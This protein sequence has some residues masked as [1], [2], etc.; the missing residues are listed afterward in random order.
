MPYL[1]KLQVLTSLHKVRRMTSRAK[2]RNYIP[3]SSELVSCDLPVKLSFSLGQKILYKAYELGHNTNTTSE[4]VK[5]H[6]PH[7]LLPRLIF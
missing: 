5:Q 2:V 4:L 6:D 1:L 3:V 7:S